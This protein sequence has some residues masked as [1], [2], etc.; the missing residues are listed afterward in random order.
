MIHHIESPCGT[1]KIAYDD[2]LGTLK[3]FARSPSGGRMTRV[4]LREVNDLDLLKRLA[5][6]LTERR[7][8][9]ERI[10]STKWRE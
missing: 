8:S 2:I 3:A 5:D 1:H 10:D 9:G 4:K 6:H 7:R